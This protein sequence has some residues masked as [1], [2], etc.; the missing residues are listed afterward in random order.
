MRVSSYSLPQRAMH[1]SDYTVVVSHS[2]PTP[3]GRCTAFTLR[4]TRNQ[5]ITRILFDVGDHTRI[6][7]HLPIVRRIKA[8][9]EVEIGASEVQPDLFGYA[10]QCFQTIREQHH[11]RF[12]DWSDWTWC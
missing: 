5:L 6:E 2:C 8:T 1:F 4:K 9:I 11:I 10:F 7:D 3:W 12:I